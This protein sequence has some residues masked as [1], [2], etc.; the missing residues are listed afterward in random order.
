M[1][2]STTICS[3]VA[4]IL[5]IIG[6][7]YMIEAITPKYNKVDKENNIIKKDTPSSEN[8]PN[9]FTKNLINIVT[10]CKS[11]KN[12]LEPQFLER[13]HSSC[14]YQI[15]NNIGE[16]HISFK[17]SYIVREEL[18][19]IIRDYGYYN[20]WEDKEGFKYFKRKSGSVAKQKEQENIENGILSIDVHDYKNRIVGLHFKDIN[21]SIKF[22]NERELIIITNINNLSRSLLIKL[23]QL[24][25]EFNYYKL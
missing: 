9:L 14:I 3:I 7:Y 15:L 25:I 1:S 17:D 16:I 8:N 4:A 20:F 23:I 11:N 6:F 10:S 18:V 19:Y 24:R 5:I 12:T 13:H 21:S 2:V 22:D